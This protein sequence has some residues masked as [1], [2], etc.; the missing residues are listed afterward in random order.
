MKFKN[1]GFIDANNNKLF[2]EVDL[3]KDTFPIIEENKE[4][5]WRRIHPMSM[6][7]HGLV[8]EFDE[9]TV[10]IFDD[11]DI[12]GYPTVAMDS[13]IAVYFGKPAKC[14]SG[15]WSLIVNDQEGG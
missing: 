15:K 2:I 9:K 7:K 12:F 13:V 11:E 10:C 1:F 3:N 14:S 4:E 5:G 6:R 8:W